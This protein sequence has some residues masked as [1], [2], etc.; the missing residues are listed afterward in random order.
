V[1]GPD[2]GFGG[3]V[4]GATSVGGLGSRWLGGQRSNLLPPAAV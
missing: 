4:S 1:V 2:L 3:P